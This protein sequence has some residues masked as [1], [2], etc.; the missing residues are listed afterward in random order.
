MFSAPLRLLM[1]A[2]LLLATACASAGK[3]VD[4]GMRLEQS[5]RPAEAARRYADALRRDPSLAEARQRLQESGDRAI[6]DYVEQAAAQPSEDAADRYVEADELLRIASNVGVNLRTPDDYA[7]RRRSAF[8]AAIEDAVT[9]SADA[10]ARGEWETAAARLTRAAGRWEA[11]DFQRASLNRARF[12]LYTRWAGMA[13]RSEEY[14]AAFTRAQQAIDVVGPGAPEAPR[15]MDIQAEALRRGTIHVAVLPAGVVS[16]Q[17]AKLPSGLLEEL[18]D[19]LMTERWRQQVPFIAIADPRE[20][21]REARR[22]GYLRQVPTRAEA[23]SL[24]D[25]MQAEVA[26]MLVID[27]VE[28]SDVDVQNLRLPVRT[29]AGVDTAYTVTTGRHRMR[30]RLAY[31]LIDVDG[32]QQP[33]RYAVWGDASVRFRRGSFHGDPG[34]LVLPNRADREIFAA[35]APSFGS[36]QVRE[37]VNDLG[38]ALERELTTTLGRR[39]R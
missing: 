37:L 38:S 35:A 4:Q 9:A 1:F 5:G 10:T 30:V 32:Y 25:A 18:N 2:P 34:Q 22:R 28:V 27:S 3:R 19:D 26:A 33:E 13:L 12:D 8:D 14:R 20:V 23:R 31:N 21:M 24:G 15:A 36:D 16:D 7:G 39:V 6:E 29:Q 17:R 11:N